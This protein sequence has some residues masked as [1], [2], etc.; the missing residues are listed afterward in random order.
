[1]RYTYPFSVADLPGLIEGAAER[2]AGLGAQF[3]SLIEGCSLLIYL[4]DVGTLLSSGSGTFHTSEV[5][6]HFECQLGMLRR[7]LEIF[8]PQ[9]VE[10]SKRTSFIIGTK[11]DLVVP[12][13]GDREGTL[14]KIAACLADAA[15]EVGLQKPE[16]LLISARRGD[17]IER[18]VELLGQKKSVDQ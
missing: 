2:N 12:Q 4:V 17:N 7:E 11:I 10:D 1:M 6:A 9:L 5:T 16:V 18:L 3:L 15:K 13:T 14:K 8:N